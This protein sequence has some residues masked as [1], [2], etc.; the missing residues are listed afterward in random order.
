MKNVK[1]FYTGVGLACVAIVGISVIT[2]KLGKE[3]T[4]EIVSGVKKQ[5]APVFLTLKNDLTAINQDNQEVSLYDLKG[6]VWLFS[7]FFIRCPQCSQRN[8]DDLK[9]FMDEFQSDPDFHMVSMSLNAEY[10]KV[11]K[12]SEY[13]NLY[14]AS[15]SRWWFLTGDQDKLRNYVSSEMKFLDVKERTDEKEISEKGLFAHDLSIALFDKNLNMRAKIDLNFA[16]A[17]DEKFYQDMVKEL[18]LR[19]NQVLAE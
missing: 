8:F 9:M 10:D 11:D 2:Q 16:K 17:Q 12:L 5:A 18:K 7:Q 19:I 4:D 3:Q 6:K 14:E 15:T 13:A 1:L